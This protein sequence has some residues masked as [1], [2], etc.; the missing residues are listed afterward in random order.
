MTGEELFQYLKSLTKEQRKTPVVFSVRHVGEVD[1][2]GWYSKEDIF[3]SSLGSRRCFGR[4]R[5][6]DVIVLE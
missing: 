3:S 1:G 2:L 4:G 6:E 5:N